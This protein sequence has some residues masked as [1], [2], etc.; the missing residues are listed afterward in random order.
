METIGD[1]IRAAR[2]NRGFTQAQLAEKAGMERTDINRAENDGLALGE[3]RLK[4]VADALD[5]SVLELRPAAAPDERGRSLLDR[6]EEVAASQAQILENQK[7]GVAAL[8]A[9][10]RAVQRT[11]ESLAEAERTAPKRSRRPGR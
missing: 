10:L 1:R 8:A 9:Q 2:K 5:V 3:K 11:V 7:K 6:L 4:R